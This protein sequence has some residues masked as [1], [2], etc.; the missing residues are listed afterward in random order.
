MACYAFPACDEP[1][2]ARMSCSETTC[3][4]TD[5]VTTGDVC[6]FWSFYQNRMFEWSRFRP[7]CSK[8]QVGLAHFI[9]KNTEVPQWS[10]MC[11]V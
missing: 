8:P 11:F 4:S 7:S 1:A 6:S 10:H 9:A 5:D 3:V 2:C